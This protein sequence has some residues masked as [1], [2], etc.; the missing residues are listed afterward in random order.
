MKMSVQQ[1][2]AAARAEITGHTPAEAARHYLRR[3]QAG[4]GTNIHDSLLEGAYLFAENHNSNTI[5][6][7][8]RSAE[9]G[10]LTP[11]GQVLADSPT[12]VC[13]VFAPIS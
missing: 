3:L 11:T 13:M 2:I 6:Q 4:G 5:V 1:M 8:H 10:E 9:T 7:F 12:P